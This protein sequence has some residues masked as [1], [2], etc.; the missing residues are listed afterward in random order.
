MLGGGTGN[1]GKFGK[2]PLVLW[3]NNI[4]GPKIFRL[5]IPPPLFPVKVRFRK[6]F[7]L[8]K[9]KLTVPFVKVSFGLNP[10]FAAK[11]TKLLSG[12]KN[13]DE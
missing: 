7:L 13:A 6:L 8:N 11:F 3:Y 1:G 4:R 12:I 10:F 5:I 2:L 9:F